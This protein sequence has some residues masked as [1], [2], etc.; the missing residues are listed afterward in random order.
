MP[1]PDRHREP[2]EKANKGVTYR[3][4]L[5]CFRFLG[6]YR[7]LNVPRMPSRASC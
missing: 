7:G 2:L 1:E 4:P 3:N 6:T 5:L